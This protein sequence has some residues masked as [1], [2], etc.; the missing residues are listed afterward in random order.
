MMKT[1]AWEKAMQIIC[2]AVLALT[3]C[4]ARADTLTLDGDQALDT[5]AP[6]A[7][8]FRDSD[9]TVERT[10]TDPRRFDF[11]GA[12]AGA[13]D[14][15]AHR[16]HS[17]REK[18][19]PESVVLDL[20]G[21]SLAGTGPIALD[22]RL[23]NRENSDSIA[24]VNAGDIAIG[25][26]ETSCE[27]GGD[28]GAI[29]IGSAERPA[30]SVR[31]G[32]LHAAATSGK[33]GRGGNI[34][35]HGS[36]DVRI[37]AANGEPGDIRSFGGRFHGGNVMVYHRG[38]LLVRHLH[39]Y[40][41]SAFGR[42]GWVGSIRLDGGNAAGDAEILGDVTFSAQLRNSGGPH[43]FEARNYRN[44]R[45]GGAIEGYSSHNRANHVIIADIS[46]DIAIAG[47]IDLERRTPGRLR[48]DE[49]ENNGRLV[50]EAGGTVTLAELDLRLVSEALLSS[51][52]GKG[53][54]AIRGALTGFDPDATGGAG[55][56]ADPFL[57]SQTVLRAPEG[58][59]I[60]Y[61]ISLPEH[62]AFAPFSYRV[63]DSYG[64]PGNGGLLMPDPGM[65]AIAA[66]EPQ[67]EADGRIVLPATLISAGRSPATVSVFWGE[68]GDRGTDR[69]A[70]PHTHAWGAHTGALPA[71]FTHVIAARPATRYTYRFAVRNAE[72]EMWTPPQSSARA[73]RV[74][75][76]A[77]IGPARWLDGADA[78]VSFTWD[79]NLASQRDIATIFNE[80]GWRS[81]FV[82]NPGQ[83]ET[84]EP[85]K[86]GYAAM[87]REGHEI[88]NHTYRHGRL[89]RMKP[90]RLASEIVQAAEA[91]E[92]LTGRYPVSFVHPY[93][94]TNEDVDRVVFQH[95]LVARISSPYGMDGRVIHNDPGSLP[96]FQRS[97]DRVATPGTADSGGWLIVGA[98]G[99]DGDG[100][101]PI[102]EGQL[103]AILDHLKARPENL[104]VGTMGEVGVYESAFKTVAVEAEYTYDTV[105]LRV[106]GF[107]AEKY[108]RAPKVPLTVA[109]P[110]R[111]PLELPQIRLDPDGVSA[112]IADGRLLMTFDLKKTNTA[113]LKL[114]RS[115]LSGVA[116][117][118]M[119]G[120][121]RKFVR[122]AG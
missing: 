111:A 87:S 44:V 14:L 68:G 65:A 26:I 71:D 40:T 70:W 15:G 12:K 104:W 48:S 21:A 92:K 114:P 83:K 59:R 47:R 96:S 38:N 50:L 86:D 46:G 54:S 119:G 118:A 10:G 121:S 112:R 41:R 82:V 64:Q 67:A 49:P 52:G 105:T 88:G 106:T 69:T 43:S 107:D 42:S 110:L 77:A 23:G 35:V 100:F 116:S 80:Y 66:R 108:A 79:D 51:G 58:A 98:H 117:P 72:G 94:A 53:A 1:G 85:L 89:I 8:R 39:A 102:K 11:S 36:G 7:I 20:G 18:G 33:A 5:G 16:L 76:I 25:G 81:T 78:A 32:F 22:L 120:R 113:T 122:Y 84:W 17:S 95:K 63:A 37:A 3:P 91:I 56:P 99:M 109:V 115:A 74:F 4:L 2:C 31:I 24:L 61:D 30:G 73:A 101:R 34:A 60:Y 19:E 13:I 75:D 45:I 9:R 57:A 27:A 97:L 29:E 55:T 62:A 90:D 93:N 6:P 28:A 103:R